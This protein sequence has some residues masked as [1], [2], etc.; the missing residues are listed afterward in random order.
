MNCARSQFG[1]DIVV[2]H[3]VLKNISRTYFS[4][5]GPR[6]QG[7]CW[8]VCGSGVPSYDFLNLYSVFDDRFSISFPSEMART[9][10][11]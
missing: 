4:R 5:E 10:E 3:A 8:G 2:A 11:P 7:A 9:K 6:S 1:R